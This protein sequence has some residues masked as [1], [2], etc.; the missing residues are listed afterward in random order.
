[1][2]PTVFSENTNRL[3][4][5]KTNAKLKRDL[6]GFASAPYFSFHGSPFRPLATAAISDYSSTPL[7]VILLFLLHL[8]MRKW[9]AKPLNEICAASSYQPLKSLER[10]RRVG[11]RS[12]VAFGL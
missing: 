4:L 8:L 5:R 9:R 11:S 6:P 1:M 12:I 3:M 10:G 2:V 7:R